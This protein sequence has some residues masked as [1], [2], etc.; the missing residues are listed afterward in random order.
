MSGVILFMA[1]SFVRMVKNARS[2]KGNPEGFNDLR[3]A[4]ERCQN[5]K[6]E[7]H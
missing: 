7:Y 6:R 3:I 5:E 4:I 1:F 2:M